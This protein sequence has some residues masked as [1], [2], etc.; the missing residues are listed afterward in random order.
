MKKDTKKGTQ[1]TEHP[2][3]YKARGEESKG[4]E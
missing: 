1:Q 3:G 4:E 2:Q